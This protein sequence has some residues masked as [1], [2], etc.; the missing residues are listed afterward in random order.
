MEIIL[1]VPGA[2]KPSPRLLEVL[3]HSLT[4]SKHNTDCHLLRDFVN[5]VLTEVQRVRLEI[6]RFLRLYDLGET[7][8]QTLLCFA[9]FLCSPG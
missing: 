5:T 1:I 7:M 2:I 8:K 3:V 4:V 9:D 6:S